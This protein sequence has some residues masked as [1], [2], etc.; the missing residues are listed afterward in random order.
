MLTA[1]WGYHEKGKSRWQ[2]DRD[3]YMRRG[4]LT[5]HCFAASMH[6]KPVPQPRSRTL[7]GG[8]IKSWTVN[9]PDILAGAM[10]PQLSLHRGGKRSAY[11]SGGVLTSPEAYGC[12]RED[13]QPLKNGQSRASAQG[14]SSLASYGRMEKMKWAGIVETLATVA[15]FLD[16]G[17]DD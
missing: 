8:V 5:G 17:M 15:C 12:S 7:S 4:T 10:W 14:R 16:H 2:Q 1:K 11:R 9:R 13:T 6:Q 3:S